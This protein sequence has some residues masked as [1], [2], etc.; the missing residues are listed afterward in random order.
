MKTFPIPPIFKYLFEILKIGDI[1]IFYNISKDEIKNI[2]N[3]NTII[4]VKLII[5]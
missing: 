2:N 5:K 3:I 1:G 4:R